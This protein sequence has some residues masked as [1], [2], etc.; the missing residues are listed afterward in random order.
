MT[1]LPSRGMWP[2][3]VFIQIFSAIYAISSW[4]FRRHNHIAQVVPTKCK[5]LLG[6]ETCIKDRRSVCLRCFGARNVCSRVLLALQRL[7]V[8]FIFFLSEWEP[9]AGTVRVSGRSFFLSIEGN[10]S[11]T[12]VWSALRRWSPIIHSHHRR[13]L[14]RTTQKKIACTEACTKRTSDSNKILF[15]ILSFSPSF[16]RLT[17]ARLNCVLAMRYFEKKTGQ[18]QNAGKK[19][20]L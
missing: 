14:S 19:F 8:H 16:S 15:C 10:L 3:F 6:S 1:F 13:H 17:I 2:L 7:S 5:S 4:I 9:W 12:T 18:Q 20:S 11:C